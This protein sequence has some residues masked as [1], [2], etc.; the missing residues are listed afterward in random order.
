[1]HKRHIDPI[2]NGRVRLRL[3]QEADLAMT[4][5]WRNQDHIRPWFF[6]NDVVSEEQHRAWFDHY[7]NVM[8]TSSS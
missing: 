1:L 7:N 6:T 2:V 5:A 3:L 8:T 4:R